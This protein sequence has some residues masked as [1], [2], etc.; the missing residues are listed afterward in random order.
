MN[1]LAEY[2]SVINSPIEGY[3]N[4]ITTGEAY[5]KNLESLNESDSATIQYNSSNLK[6]RISQSLLLNSEITEHQFQALV[7]FIMAIIEIEESCDC[8]LKDIKVS[9]SVENEIVFYRKSIVGVSI[10]SIDTDGD[11]LY[12]FTGYKNGFDT[13]RYPFNDQVDF[14][15]LIYYFLSR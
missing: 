5:N 3:E 8:E 11:L 1:Y 7:S 9:P 6:K 15:K 12:N 10:L 14:E 13:Q 4:S 2:D